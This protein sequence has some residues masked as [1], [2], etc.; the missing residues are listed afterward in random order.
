MTGRVGR[1]EQLAD[2]VHALHAP[3]LMYLGLFQVGSRMTALRL[4]DGSVLLHSPVPLD[5]AVKD[6][7]DA[8]GPVRFIVAPNLYHHLFVGDAARAWPDA[9]IVAPA[10][11]RKKRKDLAIAVDL[12]SPPAAWQGIVDVF[13]IAG[14]MLG[15]TVLLHRP[16]GTLV[17]ADLVENFSSMDHAITRA[18]LKLG[19][20]YGTPGWHRM[21]RFVYRN[22]KAARA[23]L[24]AM[25]DQPFERVVVAHGEPL[26]NRPKETLQQALAFLLT[27][28]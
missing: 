3:G 6:A 7:I 27:A 20:L 4:A 13:P 18:Y 25:L 28:R 11:L 14:S 2:G 26:V 5:V 1:L 10:A 12:E 24:E 23:S 8:I 21:M 19:G 16:T 17:S 9:A 15:E 22:K